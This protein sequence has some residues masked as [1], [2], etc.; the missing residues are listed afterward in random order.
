KKNMI[1]GQ[2][3]GWKVANTVLGFER[4]GVHRIAAT[5]RNLDRITAYAKETKRNGVP[6]FK[7]P[8]IRSRLASLHAES[9]AVRVLAYRIVW[10]HST[11]KGRDIRREASTGRLSGAL[12][13]QHVW[14][15]W[16]RTA[17]STPAHSGL[18]RRIS[19]ASISI[20]WEPPSGR[21]RRK[22]SGISS[23]PGVWDCPRTRPK[24]NPRTGQPGVWLRQQT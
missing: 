7:D 8:V 22:S 4:S 12:F 15:S 23:P 14:T 3:Q 1:G 19:A 13:Q 18:P 10:L 5:W 16:G 17:S 2:G 9:Q 20:R 11:A 24:N 6:L 21:A